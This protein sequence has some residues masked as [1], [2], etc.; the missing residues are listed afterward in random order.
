M[1]KRMNI[2]SLKVKSFVTETAKTENDA[3]KGGDPVDTYYGYNGCSFRRYPC[4][5]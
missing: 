2:S 3:V 5:L 1:K 4:F